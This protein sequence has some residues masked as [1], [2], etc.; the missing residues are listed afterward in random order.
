MNR[1]E[2]TVQ[3]VLTD[4]QNVQTEQIS[5]MKFDGPVENWSFISVPNDRLFQLQLPPGFA[6]SSSLSNDR[7]L[8]KYC[9]ILNDH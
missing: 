6:H 8:L 2:L 9:Q 1:L 3:K 5:G 7:S 4:R